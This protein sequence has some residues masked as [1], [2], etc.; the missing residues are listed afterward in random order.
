MQVEK[1]RLRALGKD[2]GDQCLGVTLGGQGGEAGVTGGLSRAIAHAEGQIWQPDPMGKKAPSG[3]G[4]G[5]R[6]QDKGLCTGGNGGFK[7]AGRKEG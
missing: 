2:Q 6:R 3:L 4:S 7:E 1:W 5:F